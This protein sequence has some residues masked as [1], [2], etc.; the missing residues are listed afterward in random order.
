MKC[1]LVVI[2]LL[3]SAVVG[4]LGCSHSSDDSPPK[5]YLNHEYGY[6]ITYPG[7]WYFEEFNPNEIGVKPRDNQYNQIQIHSEHGQPLIGVIANSL[8]AASVEAALQQFYD[9]LGARNLNVFVNG[10]ASGKWDWVAVF[11]VIY[12]E[13]PLQ[14]AMFIKETQSTCYTLVLIRL[15]DWPEG[16]A[17]FE[18]FRLIR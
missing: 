16:Q 14:G 10:P 12:D 15:G 13:T 5:E 1:K 11:T 7:N 17:V 2:C 9:V 18:S 8:Y 6:A 4:V 3:C